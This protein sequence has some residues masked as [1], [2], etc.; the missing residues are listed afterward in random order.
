M[1]HFGVQI[2]QGPIVKLS[3]LSSQT[4]CYFT[5]L[6]RTVFTVRATCERNLSFN[7]TSEL[8][9]IGTLHFALYLLI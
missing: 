2:P 9:N 1:L 7:V 3:V 4:D 6:M 5:I 8:K